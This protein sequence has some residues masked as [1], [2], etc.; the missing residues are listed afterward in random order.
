MNF[1]SWIFVFPFKSHIKKKKS[2]II[3]SEKDFLSRITYRIFA[4][5]SAPRNSF[6]VVPSFRMT[7]FTTLIQ[8]CASC[9][10]SFSSCCS[11]YLLFSGIAV[12]LL[13]RTM[14]SLFCSSEPSVLF[15]V[16]SV[17]LQMSWWVTRKILRLKAQT[18]IDRQRC[19]KIIQKVSF[20]ISSEASYVY[21]LSGQKLIKNAK[22]SQF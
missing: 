16:V 17:V 12:Q 5:L 4:N 21:I 13:R 10:S 11:S 6:D 2:V 19:L 22:N 20:N 3:S 7:D 1:R 18:E 14:T 8:K 9:L 15:F